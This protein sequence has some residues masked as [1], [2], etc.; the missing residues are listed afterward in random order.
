MLRQLRAQPG[1]DRG[2][3]GHER[4]RARGCG[5]GA[6]G[7]DEGGFGRA[8]VYRLTQRAGVSCGGGARNA[9]RTTHL[10]TVETVISPARFSQ[11]VLPGTGPSNI[12]PTPS[13]A[14]IFCAS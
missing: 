4:Y 12:L 3:V 8:G 13:P 2:V 11:P 9:V 10:R 7:A 6:G 14:P 1:G 5:A